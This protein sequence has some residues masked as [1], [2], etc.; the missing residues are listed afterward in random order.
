VTERMLVTLYIGVKALAANSHKPA[1][2]FQDPT[3][4]FRPC[5]L[6]VVTL[7]N[8]GSNWMN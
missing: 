7:E 5:F 6:G 3:S 2:S 8:T 4:E 1:F